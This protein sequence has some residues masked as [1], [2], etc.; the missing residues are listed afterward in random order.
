MKADISIVQSKKGTEIMVSGN[1]INKY[2][3]LAAILFYSTHTA[4]I[5][6]DTWRRYGSC[7]ISDILVVRPGRLWSKSIASCTFLRNLFAQRFPVHLFR[8]A[9]GRHTFLSLQRTHQNVAISHNL[10]LTYSV[11]RH[12]SA[13][14]WHGNRELLFHIIRNI[15]TYR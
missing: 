4:L 6:M 11:V 7:I 1:K 2:G 5:P 10:L 3:I 9:Q 12:T 8:K 13:F 14:V 15:L